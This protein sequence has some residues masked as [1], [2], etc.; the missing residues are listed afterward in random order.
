[1]GANSTRESFVR[2]L[3]RAL[4]HL[5]NP[6]TLR[7]SPLVQLFGVDQ[8]ADAIS[9]LQRILTDAIEA[10]KPDESVPP[11]S[12][13][14]RLYHVLYYRY[15]EQFTQ[16]EVATDLAL[17]IR[18]L[19][20]Q[21]KVALQVLADY[22]WAHYSLEHRAHLFSPSSQTDDQMG[23]QDLSAR[24]GTPSWEQELEWLE[25]TIPSESVDVREVIP[26]VLE[27]VRPLVQTLKVSMKYSLPDNL[28]P[29]T[30]QLTTMRQALLHI[31]TMAARHVPGGQVTI[32]AK[33][34]PRRA[35]VRMR[36]VARRAGPSS[37][38]T[39]NSVGTTNTKNLEMARDLI[40]LSGGS[41]EVALDDG[42][43][44]PFT[45]S[46]MLPT[47]EQVPVLVIDDNVDT[48]Q[49]LQRY[50]SGS[51]YRF[52]GTSDPQEGLALAEQLAPEIIVLDVMLPDVDGWE[53]LG[54]LREH[55]KT[56]GVPIVVCTILPQ[57]QLALTLGAAEFIRKPVS[58]RALLSVLDR[59]IDRLLRESR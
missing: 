43:K 37:M 35:Y 55:P 27:I 39:M 47:A 5:Y 42:A 4:P 51:H 25:R 6:G 2:E 52:I 33:A 50:L 57:E 54:R 59:Q 45:A 16:R 12:N 19:R 11:G 41:I 34:L 58:R 10:L 31:V 29:L 44:M 20:R 30:V 14:W 9:A 3:G 28:P 26:A 38:G 13:A 7:R 53:L 36:V 23:E 8:R 24:V 21:E 48:L 17:S 1:M 15:T 22:L 40:R 32:V 18:Q 56:R 49:L 46:I